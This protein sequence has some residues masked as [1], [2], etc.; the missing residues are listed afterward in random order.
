MFNVGKCAFS[1]RTVRAAYLHLSGKWFWEL[2]VKTLNNMLFVYGRIN[3]T[4]NTLFLPLEND[5]VYSTHLWNLPV[6]ALINRASW[7]SPCASLRPSLQEDWQFPS[8]FPQDPGEKPTLEG[9]LGPSQQ[10]APIC[11]ACESH[12]GSGSSSPSQ[13]TSAS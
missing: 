10:S 1:C 7:K 11:Q 13:A 8:P 4:T 3:M 12:L 2:R 6:T 5:V 9:T